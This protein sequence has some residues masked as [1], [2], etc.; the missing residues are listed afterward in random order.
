LL[1]QLLAAKLN[2]AAFGCSASTVTN[3]A[4]A[5]LAYKLGANKNTIMYYSG[6]LDAYNNSG[7]NG[8]IPP[9]L[10]ATG[11]ATPKTSQSIADKSFWNQ[12]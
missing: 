10:G 11:K 3:I 9:V 12:P 7:D 4:G 6:L 8:A 1:Q 2:C 5:D